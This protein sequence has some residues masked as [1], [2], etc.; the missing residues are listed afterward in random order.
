MNHFSKKRSNLIHIKH[1]VQSPIQDKDEKMVAMFMNEL[2]NDYYEWRNM[3]T[4]DEK[5]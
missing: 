5:D 3:Q 2:I 1:L 4:Y